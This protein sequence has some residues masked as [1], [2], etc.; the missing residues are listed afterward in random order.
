MTHDAM[1]LLDD[2]CDAKCHRGF[3]TLRH[4]KIVKTTKI[5]MK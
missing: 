1:S 5:G 4:I 2:K 3:V